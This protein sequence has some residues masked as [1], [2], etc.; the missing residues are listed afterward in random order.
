ML[1]RKEGVR[2]I[3]GLVSQLEVSGLGSPIINFPSR[4]V[5]NCM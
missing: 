2:A 5:M 3:T 1:S 4:Q